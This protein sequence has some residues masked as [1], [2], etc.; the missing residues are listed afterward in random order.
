MI[1]ETEIGYLNN[2]LTNEHHLTFLYDVRIEEGLQKIIL[3]PTFFQNNEGFEIHSQI[4]WKNIIFELVLGNKAGNLLLAMEEEQKND[5]N[6]FVKFYNYLIDVM[7]AKLVIKINDSALSMKDTENWPIFWRNLNVQMKTPIIDNESGLINEADVFDHYRKWLF[8]YVGLVFQLVNLEKIIKFNPNG[9]IDSNQEGA[10]LIQLQKRFER[11]P[12]N[13]LACLSVYGFN[14][15][16]CGLNFE[17][18]Y[19]TIGTGFIEV[20][21]QIP[22]GSIIGSFVVNPITDLVPI[23][24]NCHSMVHRKNPPYTVNE[25]RSFLSEN[26]KN[27]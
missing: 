22:L 21:H 3:R 6:G 17:E 9:E 18:K 20:H 13:R 15:Q 12:K 11:N 24:S 16:A 10:E 25:L 14:C 7:K 27:H 23:C 26:K 8:L 1:T 19:G 2:L 5:R 4:G